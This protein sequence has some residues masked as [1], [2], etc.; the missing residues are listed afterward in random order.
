MASAAYITRTLDPV[1][2]PAWVAQDHAFDQGFQKLNDSMHSVQY[3]KEYV[4]HFRR[5]QANCLDWAGD[6]LLAS[7]QGDDVFMIDMKGDV[8]RRWES[9]WYQMQTHPTDQNIVACVEGNGGRF[10]I[11]DVRSPAGSSEKPK[12]VQD[13]DLSKTWST[14]KEFLNITWSPDGNHI[15]INNQ[16]EEIFLLDVRQAGDSAMRMSGYANFGTEAAVN[17]MA[18]ST[19]SQALLVGDSNGKITALEAPDLKRSSTASVHAH[20][21]SVSALAVDGSGSCVA[22]ASSDCLVCLWDPRHMVC[23]GTFGFA[24]QC[25]QTMSFNHD[26]ALLA[27]GTG[28]TGSSGGEKN[29]TIVGSNTGVLYWQ[30]TTSAPVY[31]VK[32]HRRKN[33]LAYALNAAQLPED[34]DRRTSRETAALHLLTLPDPLV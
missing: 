32:F 27:W 2:S 15:A 19:G 8:V 30:D 22:S 34:R 20:I 21:G 10:R 18:W 24:T 6:N 17:V 4:R 31:A 7:A 33:I 11:C 16:N 14:M 9:D 1:L 29:L 13:V 5:L 28:T 26:C 12:Y 3:G 23:L 25:P